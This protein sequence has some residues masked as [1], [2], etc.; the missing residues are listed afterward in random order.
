MYISLNDVYV[1]SHYFKAFMNYNQFFL[2]NVMIKLME[3]FTT[4]YWK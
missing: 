3:T 4:A 1:N 2:S